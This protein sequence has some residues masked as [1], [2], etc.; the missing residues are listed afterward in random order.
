MPCKE[1]RACL[2]YIFTNKQTKLN[3]RFPRNSGTGATFGLFA[4]RERDLRFSRALGVREGLSRE[5][6]APAIIHHRNNRHPV[7]EEK[8]DAVRIWPKKWPLSARKTEQ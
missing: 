7:P 6:T 5:V 8:S 2:S 1:I 4:L 3:L